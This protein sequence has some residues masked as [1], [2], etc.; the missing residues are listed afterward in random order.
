MTA[1][2]LDDKSVELLEYRHLIQRPKNRK[3]WGY[4]FGDDIGRL[5]QGM[6]GRNTGTNTTYFIHKHEIPA[7]RWK[8]VTSGRIVCN[9]TPQ[10]EE[11]FCTRLTVDGSRIN[12]GMDCGAPTASLLTVKLLLS[13]F[14]ST[15]N[16]R[17]ISI[18]IK[19][20][21]LNT[22]MKRPEFL[23]L[24]IKNFPKDVT[25]NYNLFDKVDAKGNLYINVSKECVA[26]LMQA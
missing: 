15:E 13:S 3:D 18:D 5:A 4:S 12:I 9:A 25:Q 16:V 10:K 26:C 7:D 21:Y 19:D 2:V 14:I 20:F 22:P 11:V 6:L 8:D 17:F 1:A 24:K 23:R